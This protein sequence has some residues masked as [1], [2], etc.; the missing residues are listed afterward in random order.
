MH[1]D[2]TRQ[3]WLAIRFASFKSQP[4]GLWVETAQ[5][6]GRRPRAGL[7]GV[8]VERGPWG[9]LCSQLG[10]DPGLHLGMVLAE[11]VS[12]SKQGTRERP[13]FSE[14]HIRE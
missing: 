9:G 3:K 4:S 8:G 6:G 12:K 7:W 2:K 14:A 5:V 11:T 1:T 13:M 10:P